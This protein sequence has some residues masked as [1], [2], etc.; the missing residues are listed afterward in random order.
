MTITR[1][2]LIAA[3]A[4]LAAYLTASASAGAQE[5]NR[6]SVEALLNDL[7]A[8]NRFLA[9]RE[10]FDGYGHVS[11]R[12]PASPNRYLMARSL[13]PPLVTAA[14]ILTYNLDSNPLN[15]NEAHTF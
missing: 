6:P 2:E 9:Q 14:D 10:V 5:A 7:V 1:R 4:G 8:A 15:A 3:S 12:H 13:A 11:V